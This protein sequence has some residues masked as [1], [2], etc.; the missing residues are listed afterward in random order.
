MSEKKEKEKFI[1]KDSKA[2]EDSYS[3]E[4]KSDN[5]EMKEYDFNEVLKGR[6]MKLKAYI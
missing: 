1:R 3:L 5:F 6:Q 2:Q 4:T